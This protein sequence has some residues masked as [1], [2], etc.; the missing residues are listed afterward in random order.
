MSCG[1]RFLQ[2]EVSNLTL[3]RLV[4]LIFQTYPPISEVLFTKLQHINRTLY[5]HQFL[6]VSSSFFM[7][8]LLHHDGLPFFHW[9]SPGQTLHLPPT[10][11][12]IH[13]LAL[14]RTRLLKDTAILK[15]FFFNPVVGVFGPGTTSFLRNK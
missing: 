13:L 2:S 3:P 15:N 12:R 11:L 8:A 4:R 5:P 7:L 10:Q 6:F 9:S 14:G 1:C